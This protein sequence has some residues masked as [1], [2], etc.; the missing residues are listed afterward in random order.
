MRRMYKK[1]YTM[2]GKDDFSGSY[3]KQQAKSQVGFDC[4]R[5]CKHLMAPSV[6]G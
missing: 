6:I 3:Q 5:A 4:E 1:L 2:L